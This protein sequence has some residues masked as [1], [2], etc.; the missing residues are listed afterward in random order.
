[1]KFKLKLLRF[2]RRVVIYR[3]FSSYPQRN[4][5][6]G[7]VLYALIGFL[8][9]LLP[10]SHRLECSAIDDLFSAVSAISTT[11]L[12]TVDTSATYSIFGQIILLA[13]IQLGGIGYMTLSS[14]IFYRMTHHSLRYSDEVIKTSIAIPAGVNMRTLVRNVL[15][16][17]LIFEVIGAILLY[18]CF[19]I[20][21]LQ[22]PLWNAIFI[23]ISSFC[24]AGFSP[25]SDSLCSL[26][27]SVM[28]NIVVTML[29]YAGG[30]G[31]IVITDCLQK[32]R[33]I[34]HKVS[35]TTKVILFITSLLTIIGTTILTVSSR[36]EF[37]SFGHCL[38]SSF[39]HTMSAMTT[40]GFNTIDISSLSLFAVLIMCMIMFIGASPSG[41]GG[42]VKSTSISA[43]YAFIKSRLRP[44]SG[45]QIMG[46][47]LPWYRV[48]NAL[49]NFI[50]YV[51]I[52]S[53]GLLLLVAVEPLPLEDL[54]FETLSALGT[55]GLSLGI[56]S[57][58]S[59]IGKIII[60]VIMFIGRIGVITFASALLKK[61]IHQ[62]RPIKRDDL[63]V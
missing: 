27:D 57:S 42:G 15:F 22:A 18:I 21:G 56:T 45:I 54:M 41:T 19:L 4:I 61:I 6:I 32:I 46:H 29:A 39:F 44:N 12:S 50:L 1:M 5:A 17:T 37:D 53:C 25:F 43:I 40:V 58:L 34:H 52:F 36:G 48:D 13:L 3:R 59:T 26:R 51:L 35:F 31:F 60:I 24:T 10:W 63:A 16:F 23:S 38:L 62:T 47:K 9:L 7:Y 49:T 2:I 33:N 14:Y 20:R 28:V 8:L 11:G 55:V 30:M